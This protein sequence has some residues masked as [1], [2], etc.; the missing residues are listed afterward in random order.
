M[1]RAVKLIVLVVLII[2]CSSVA[3]AQPLNVRQGTIEG[4]LLDRGSDFVLLEAYDGTQHR[5]SVDERARFFIDDRPAFLVDFL[6]GIE[7]YVRVRDGRV[8]LLEGYS[9]ANPGYIAPGGIV[10]RGVVTGIDRDQIQ[11]MLATGD[12]E[13]FFTTPITIVQQGGIRTTLDTLYVG[14]SVR[15]YFDQVGSRLVGRVV[16]QRTESIRISNIFRGTL[17]TTDRFSNAI[18]LSNVHVFR[19]GGW[20]RYGA[21]DGSNYKRLPYNVD[22]PLYSGGFR[23]PAG[24][25]R[26]FAGS[27]AYMVTRDF[28]NTER[29][30]RLLLQSMHESLESGKILDINWFT[31]AF[32]LD[33]LRNFRFDESTIVIKNDRI[34]DMYAIFAE[35]DAFVISDGFGADRLAVLVYILNVDINSSNI[36]NHHLYVGRLDMILPN[37]VRLEDFFVLN[38][39]QWE[40]FDERREFF[41]D[42][43]TYIVNLETGQFISQTEFFSAPFSGNADRRD[44]WYAYIFANGDRIASI[45]IKQN[46]DS[47]LRQRVTTGVIDSIEDNIHVGWTARLR[48]SSDWSN[49][50]ESWFPRTAFLNV[51]LEDSMI[52][53][54]GRVIEA[55]DLR[56]GDR[57]YMV[58]DDFMGRVVI[59]R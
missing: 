1:K 33:N 18:S 30:D 8:E 40:A 7:V 56:V 22:T 38:R 34:V 57:L 28:F 49:R 52:L 39:N 37:L 13:M 10:R 23:V 55:R 15:L 58:R 19:N 9:V 5:L 42:N 29:I 31:Q 44:N 32:E 54:N 41:F 16:I 6:P 27:T 24:N 35:A 26:H 20:Q 47:L 12:R 50:H 43:D 51:N 3:S 4:F 36:G 11:V 25:L 59:V 17:S 53:R 21:T 14:D 48:N 46:L 45:G 2:F